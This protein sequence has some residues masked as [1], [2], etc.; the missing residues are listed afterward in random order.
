MAKQVL[1]IQGA[2]EGAHRDD[3][4]LAGSLRSELGENYQVRYPAMPDEED[5]D[6]ETWKSVILQE[7]EAM[8]E[9]AILV[10]HSIGASVLIRMFADRGPKPAIAGMFLIA[11]PFW[12]DH[13]FWH[14]AVSWI[15]PHG[16]VRRPLRLLSAM[17]QFGI[18]RAFRGKRAAHRLGDNARYAFLGWQ[19][20][21]APFPSAACRR[22]YRSGLF[23]RIRAQAIERSRIGRHHDAAIPSPCCAA[24]CA[25]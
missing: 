6:Y 20:A 2:G 15:M 10:G 5:A 25:A 13:E 9:G 7:V 3:A 18:I 12:H 19:P 14:Y 8:G 4:K 22:G 23:P 1:L 24:T 17:R 16:R 11:G 21:R